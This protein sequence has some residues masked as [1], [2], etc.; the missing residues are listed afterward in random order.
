VEVYGAVSDAAHAIYMP[1][2]VTL[3]DVYIDGRPSG[4]IMLVVYDGSIRGEFYAG[5]RLRVRGRLIKVKKG[6]SEFDAVAAFDA[7]DITREH[8]AR[9]VPRLRAEMRSKSAAV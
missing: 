4:D 1:P 9:G 8:L 6:K 2:V 7:G 5:E 3:S